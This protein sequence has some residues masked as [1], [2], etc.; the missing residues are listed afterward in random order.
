[1]GCRARAYSQTDDFMAEE[2]SCPY[3]RGQK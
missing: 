2:P 1:M 3:V